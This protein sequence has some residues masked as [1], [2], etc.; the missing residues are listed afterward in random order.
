MQTEKRFED[1]IEYTSYQRVFDYEG[2]PGCGYSFSCAPD[3]TIDPPKNERSRE[4]IERCL[5]R[6]DGLIDK[7]VKA[8]KS[9]VWLC[10]C[11]SGKPRYPLHDGYGIFLTHACE[12]CEGAKLSRFRPDIMDAY[13]CDEPIEPEDY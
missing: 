3:G 11:G 7:G 5:R 2:R 1:R 12:D 4:N 10:S 8:Y 9:V 6:D 13:D